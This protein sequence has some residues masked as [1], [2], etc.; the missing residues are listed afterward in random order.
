MN[1]QKEIIDYDIEESQPCWQCGGE[2]YGLSGYDWPNDDPIN[3]PDGKFDTCPCCG[4]S[5][6]AKDCTYW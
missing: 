6:D 2:G 4:G 5:G 3:N 1:Q